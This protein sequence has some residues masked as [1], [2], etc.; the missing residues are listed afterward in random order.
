MISELEG[1][2]TLRS[3]HQIFDALYALALQESRELG[4]D[5]IQDGAFNDTAYAMHLGLAGIDPTRA[6]RSLAFK[7]SERRAGGDLQIVQ[8]TGTG[9]SYPISSD[10]V[11]W[12]LGAQAVLAQLEGQD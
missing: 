4:V 8:N 12:A 7:L 2:P 6:Q 11:A 1:W 5:G 3:G 10:R 9:G